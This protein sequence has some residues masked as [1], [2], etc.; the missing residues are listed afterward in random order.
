ML[1]VKTYLPTWFDILFRNRLKTFMKNLL[2]N[3]FKK[4]YQVSL[5]LFSN[6][7]LDFSINGNVMNN[8]SWIKMKKKVN[9]LIAKVLISGSLGCETYQKVNLKEF[10][11]S[12]NIQMNS[13]RNNNYNILELVFIKYSPWYRYL[14]TFSFNFLSNSAK[15]LGVSN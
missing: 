7:I 10:L 14:H 8:D 9:V 1:S 2:R 15:Y 3:F 5:G 11:L 4:W 6:L 12:K 13:T